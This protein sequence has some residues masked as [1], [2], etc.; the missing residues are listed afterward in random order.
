MCDSATY[1]LILAYIKIMKTWNPQFS[2]VNSVPIYDNKYMEFR[3]IPCITS[4][5]TTQTDARQ[6]EFR[7]F[8]N[9]ATLCI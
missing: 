6:I 4:Q 5:N 8:S 1:M 9:I 3:E 2:N 7:Q